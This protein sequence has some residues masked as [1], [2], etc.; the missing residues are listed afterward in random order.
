MLNQEET[1]DESNK[2]GSQGVAVLENP[3]G[4]SPANGQ[5][6]DSQRSNPLI[7]KTCP[8]QGGLS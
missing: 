7:G 1:N 5:A 2:K 6:D 8:P 4:K 3:P